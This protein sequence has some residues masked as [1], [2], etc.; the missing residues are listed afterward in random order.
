[1]DQI[2]VIGLHRF[3]ETVENCYLCVLLFL[4]AVSFWDP[5]IKI[6]GRI[7]ANWSWD[8]TFI[9][10][11][12]LFVTCRVNG[13]WANWFAQV[14]DFW[15][16][17]WFFQHSYRRTCESC[18]ADLLPCIPTITWTCSLWMNKEEFNN[19]FD[20]DFL[21]FCMTKLSAISCIRRLPNFLVCLKNFWV[22]VQKNKEKIWG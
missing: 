3:K 11:N 8:S 6:W 9:P 4:K 22:C 18:V 17:V 12:I 7:E 20:S 19:L 21:L 13:L 2:D 5:D 16:L 10:V 1:M 14:T 15:A